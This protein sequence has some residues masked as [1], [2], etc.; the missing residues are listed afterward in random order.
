M[1]EVKVK[2]VTYENLSEEQKRDRN[3]LP[4]RYKKPF[5]QEIE[6][7]EKEKDETRNG[8]IK[9]Q[10]K[11]VMS[12]L[13]LKRFYGSYLVPF[14]YSEDTILRMPMRELED[15]FNRVMEHSQSI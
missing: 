12:P 8:G 1:A 5:P 15:L 4:F 13:E 11:M 2:T 9:S 14:G 3:I 10:L 7:W 6:E